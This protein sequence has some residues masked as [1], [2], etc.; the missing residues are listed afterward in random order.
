MPRAAAH[1][2]FQTSPE[3]T[4]LLLRWDSGDGAAR[5]RLM[6]LVYEQLHL[7][8]RR[9]APD[10]GGALDLQPTELVAEAWLRLDRGGLNAAHR[11]HFLALAA[12]VMR[13]V[14]VDHARRL[15]AEKRGGGWIPVTLS[16]AGAAPAG[17]PLD[18]VQFDDGLTLLGR[19]H[20]RA[21]R[22]IE[23]HYFGGV[24]EAEIA[25]ELAVSASAPAPLVPPA[26]S[27]P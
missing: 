16:Q 4:R 8:A 10:R 21:G 3:I 6:A 2:P 11:R 14:L 25:A 15:L 26:R 7:L 27:L 19:L 5:E 24:T 13:Q 12:R 18:L 23:M 20:P 1:D 17:D 9:L 22:V